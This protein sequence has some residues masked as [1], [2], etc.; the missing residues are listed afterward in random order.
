MSSSEWRIYRL[1][2]DGK[3]WSMHFI[4]C[5]PDAL[6]ESASKLEIIRYSEIKSIFLGKGSCALKNNVASFTRSDDFFFSIT[7]ADG[8]VFDFEAKSPDQREEIMSAIVLKLAQLCHKECSKNLPGRP[9]LVSCSTSANVPCTQKNNK[10]PRTHQEH[11]VQ[12]PC[13]AVPFKSTWTVTPLTT[14]ETKTYVNSFYKSSKSVV[15]TNRPPR[16]RI[17]DIFDETI[18]ANRATPPHQIFGMT[19]KKPMGKT[20]QTAGQT[21]SMSP[22]QISW[23][24]SVLNKYGIE[25]NLNTNPTS[26]SNSITLEQELPDFNFQPQHISHGKEK[27]LDKEPTSSDLKIKELC[28]ESTRVTLEYLALL[29]ARSQREIERKKSELRHDEKK[30]E[31]IKRY[32]ELVKQGTKGADGVLDFIISTNSHIELCSNSDNIL[33]EKGS[34]AKLE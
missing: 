22:N 1:G 12:C 27:R 26:T 29:Q 34:K 24:K 23:L 21:T 6:I 30:L 9:H 10:S 28:D 3:Q 32:C 4:Q 20:R 2:D 14:K 19:D 25:E 11:G 17:S 7:R 31:G 16:L 33:L 8:K 15:C 5:G 13:F 18:E